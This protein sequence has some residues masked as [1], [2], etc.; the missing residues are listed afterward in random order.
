MYESN[1]ININYRK[2]TILTTYSLLQFRSFTLHVFYD[3]FV[4]FVFVFVFFFVEEVG[5]RYYTFC[6]TNTWNCNLYIYTHQFLA[7]QRMKTSRKLSENRH[8]MY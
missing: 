3:F 1:V 8:I 7:I 6:K 2:V 4:F 5:I